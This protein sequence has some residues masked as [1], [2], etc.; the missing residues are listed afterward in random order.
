MPEAYIGGVQKK[1]DAKGAL[2]DE[3]TRKFLQEFINA[4]ADWVERNAAA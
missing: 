3:S 4:Y 1:F 2:S